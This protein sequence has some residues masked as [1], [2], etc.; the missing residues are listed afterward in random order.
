MKNTI[1]NGLMTYEFIVRGNRQLVTIG[2]EDSDENPK[3]KI[4]GPKEIIH[5]AI[6]GIGFESEDGTVTTATEVHLDTEAKRMF[7]VLEV[8]NI[9]QKG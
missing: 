7:A 6:G 4:Q 5:Q 8:L 1:E 2:I 9:M 3:F